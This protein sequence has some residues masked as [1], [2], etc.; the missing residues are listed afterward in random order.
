MDSVLEG[1]NKKKKMPFWGKMALGLVAGIAAG[2]VVSPNG[3]GLFPYDILQPTIDWVMLPAR[4]FMALITMI[5]V[6]LVFCSIFLAITGGGGLT[7]LKAAG[8][9]ITAYFLATTTAAVSLGVVLVK[10]FEP[11]R[12]VPALWLEQMTHGV[13]TAAPETSVT[14]TKSIPSLVM[15]LIPTNPASAVM[16]QEMLQIVIL[17]TLGG[18][19]VLA[20]NKKESNPIITLCEA[21]Q[22]ICMK[23]VSWAMA[24][25]PVAVFGFLFRLSAETGP[26]MLQALSVYIGTVLLGLILIGVMYLLIV[27]FVAKR[28]P[29]EFLAAVRNA[30]VLAFSSSSSAA[31]MPLSLDT[32]ENKLKVRPEIARLVIPLGTTVNMDGTAFYQIVVALF[33][34]QLT[35]IPL[36]FS[37][38]VLLA[39]T[40]IGA[41]I[42]SPGSP[43]V[44]LV[45]LATILA[46]IGVPAEAIGIVLGVDRF[47]DMCRTTINVTGDL[48]AAVV[49][50]KHVRITR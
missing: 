17:A 32:A 31:T 38:T 49:I 28:N 33:L 34:I 47:L 39:V 20:I 6:P 43:G 16:N 29:W 23:I 8:I 46:N 3:L 18:L 4:L 41:S 15:A 48:T 22:D 35:G 11:A 9:R 36:D 27:A 10:L 25:A 50:D 24:M 1:N 30:Q 12:F 26:D 21:V 19:A 7:F 37:Q 42:G 45:I 44:G 2:L 40:I 14:L 13:S 5:V